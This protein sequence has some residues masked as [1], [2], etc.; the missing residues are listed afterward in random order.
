MMLLG[1]GGSC[2]NYDSDSDDDNNNHKN[3]SDD[4]DDDDHNGH[5]EVNNGGGGG[6]GVCL[7]VG[8][9]MS[10]QHASVSRGQISSDNFKMVKYLL[11]HLCMI[12]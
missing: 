3:K 7:F 8:C 11:T 12:Y 2:H 9:L 5:E 10:Q 1:L 6:G 4:E